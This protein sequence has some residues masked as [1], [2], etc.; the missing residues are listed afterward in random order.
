M[1]Y[2]SSMGRSVARYESKGSKLLFNKSHI[3]KV[4]AGRSPVPLESALNLVRRKSPC[5]A[6]YTYACCARSNDHLFYFYDGA[7][8]S[9][10]FGRKSV[11]LF[12]QLFRA[13]NLRVCNAANIRARRQKLAPQTL[14]SR[15]FSS[16]LPGREDARKISAIV[17]KRYMY[18]P[19]PCTV[20]LCGDDCDTYAR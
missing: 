2:D 14:P 13:A 15:N 17:S 6:H 12:S 11:A 5:G 3:K 10:G 20:W 18:T 9:T 4:G 19:P 8:D 7:D 16:H 1:R